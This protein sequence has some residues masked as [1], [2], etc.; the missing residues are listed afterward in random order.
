[1]PPPASAPATMGTLA[2]MVAGRLSG[3]A[4][5]AV[6]D[7]SA[8]S[9]QIGPGWLFI[10]VPGASFDGHEFV[11]AAAGNGAAGLCVSR[12]VGSPLP[13]IEVP[14]TR[15]VMAKLA[16]SIHRFPSRMT[17]VVGVTGTNGKTT[18]TFLVESIARY[19]GRP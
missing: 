15:A 10:A 12:G 18:V 14:S 19:A 8:D 5:V 11:A 6:L 2:T 7:A 13:T 3:D 9:R 16:A 1:M 4:E 17:S